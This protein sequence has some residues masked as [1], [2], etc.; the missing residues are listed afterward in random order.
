SD[1]DSHLTGPK[2]DGSG[3]FHIYFANKN[4]VDDNSE[5]NLDVDDVSSYGP[6]TVTVLKHSSNGTYKYNVFNYSGAWIT[7]DNKNDLSKSSA[8]VEVYKGNALVK[9]YNVPT[10]KEGNMWK[11]FEVVDGEI[12]TVNSIESYDEHPNANNQ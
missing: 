10:N 1:L 7:D 3:R 12:R 4:Y 8:K 11:V 6:E 9:T 5:V 2:A